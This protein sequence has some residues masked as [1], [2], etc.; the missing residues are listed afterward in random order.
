MAVA[1]LLILD[2]SLQGGYAV[3]L[4]CISRIS[5][6]GFRGLSWSPL[7]D[8]MLLQLLELLL[9]W[10]Q[11]GMDRGNGKADVAG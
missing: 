4:A 5:E 8:L 10:N 11:R 1:S 3:A 2:A 9:R 7:L 6:Q